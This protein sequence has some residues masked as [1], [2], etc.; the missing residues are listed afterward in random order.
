MSV[1]FSPD[2]QHIVSG[3]YQTIC[4][5]NTMTGEMVAGPF[6]GHTGYVNSVAFSPDG[7]H[8]VSG[9]DDHAI[10]LWNAK[11]G[12][13]ETSGQVDFTDQSKMNDEGW[14]CGSNGELLMWIP[15]LHRTGLYRPSNVWVA[16]EHE[17]HLDL[18]NFKHGN[19]W[20]TCINA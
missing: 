10:R 9:S 6:R 20:T 8:I 11:A 19:S 15:P 16:A 2:G 12:E 17:T 18:S 7:Q 4:V 14:I 5:S 13:T 3:S 1:A